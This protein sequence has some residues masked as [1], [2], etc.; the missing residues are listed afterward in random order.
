MSGAQLARELGTS[1]PR[2]ARAVE[3]LDIDARQANG[4]LALTPSQARRVRRALGVSPSLAGLS[5]PRV[6][7]LAALRSAPFGLVS[8]R[9]VARR[10]GLSPT[11]VTSALKGLLEDGLV[12]R[13]EEVLAAGSA[14]KASIWRANLTHPRWAEIDPVLA[15]VRGPECRT[16]PS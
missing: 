15:E 2:I 7:V 6:R 4:R 8:A 9:A 14:R 11:T 1:V 16:T 12:T 10:S 3:R 13:T 5:R